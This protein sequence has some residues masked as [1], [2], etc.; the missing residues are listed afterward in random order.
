MELLVK[1]L[2]EKLSESA[3]RCKWPAARPEGEQHA[4]HNIHGKRVTK[5]ANDLTTSFFRSKQSLRLILI[6]SKFRS[7]IRIAFYYR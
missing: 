1:V 2:V 3:F 5:L 7:L 4:E 6:I